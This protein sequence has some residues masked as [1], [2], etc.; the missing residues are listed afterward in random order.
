[1]QLAYDTEILRQWLDGNFRVHPFPKE[2]LPWTTGI[3]GSAWTGA[4]IVGTASGIGIGIAGT[5]GRF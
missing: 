5:S 2:L 3:T 1:M 4:G